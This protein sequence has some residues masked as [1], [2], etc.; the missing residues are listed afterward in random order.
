MLS[1]GQRQTQKVCPSK[2][3]TL[4]QPTSEVGAHLQAGVRTA[5]ERA[6]HGC[7]LSPAGDSRACSS[8]RPG[9]AG[10]GISRAVARLRCQALALPTGLSDG[11]DLLRLRWHRVLGFGKALVYRLLG[12]TQLLVCSQLLRNFS[13]YTRVFEAIQYIF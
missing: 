6:S 12:L 7:R 9:L 4:A 10:E 11:L 2:Q 8:V 5:S 1:P 13:N 3:N